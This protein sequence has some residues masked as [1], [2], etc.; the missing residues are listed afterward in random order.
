[1]SEDKMT[2]NLMGKV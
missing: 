1:M 2:W